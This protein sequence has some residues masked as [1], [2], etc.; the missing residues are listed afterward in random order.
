MTY[1]GV[2]KTVL[3]GKESTWGTAV[4]ATKD[5]GL[6]QEIADDFS[7]EVIESSGLGA[8]DVQKI[9]SGVVDIGQTVTVDFQHGRL[10]EYVFGTVAHNADDTPDIKHTFTI[11][12]DAPSLTMESG[13]NLSTDTV[14]TQAGLL[15][16]SCEIKSELNSNLQLICSFKGKTTASTAS[17]TTAVVSS[18]AVFPHSLVGVEINNSAVSEVQNFSI[19]ITKTVERSGGLG[20]NLYQQGH[21]TSLSIEFSGTLGFSDKTIQE[22]WLGG[23]SPSGSSDPTVYDVTLNAT[24]G[25]SAASGLRQLFVD[26]ESSIGTKFTETA[27][28]GSLTFFD[29]AGKA[30]L[31]ECFSYDNIT[32]GNW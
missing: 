30:T 9:T 2:V 8:I 28:V 15:I 26:L 6:V 16:E 29:I 23:T 22:L 17:A 31:K 7:R 5:I 11:N 32:S 24:N 12:D 3:I 4:S 1:P 27:S 19:T 13:N 21:A 10:L 18:L 20:S 14:L 25:V